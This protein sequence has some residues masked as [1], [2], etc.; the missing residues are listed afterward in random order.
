MGNQTIRDHDEFDNLL[1]K[2]ADTL[3]DRYLNKESTEE[4]AQIDHQLIKQYLKKNDHD[5]NKYNKTILSI[6]EI[7]TKCTKNSDS[8]FFYNKIL[9]PAVVTKRLIHYTRDSIIS[10]TDKENAGLF[11]AAHTAQITG[12]LKTLNLKELF[13]LKEGAV[14]NFPD[15]LHHCKSGR[16]RTGAVSHFIQVNM[17]GGEGE[18]VGPKKNDINQSTLTKI[19]KPGKKYSTSIEG[20]GSI[21]AYAGHDSS[22]AMFNLSPGSLGLR[23]S[24]LNGAFCDTQKAVQGLF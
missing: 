14:P 23:A 10:P 8:W 20:I 18:L 7:C 17:M 16:D 3:P 5:G 21:A 1:S 4:G 2:L 13:G 19:I 15:I 24:T 6:E 11:I 9:Y 12:C 22:L